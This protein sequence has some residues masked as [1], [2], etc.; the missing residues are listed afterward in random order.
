MFYET[1]RNVERIMV[2]MTKKMAWEVMHEDVI[3]IV[4]NGNERKLN[5]KRSRGFIDW[6]QLKVLIDFQHK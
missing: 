1:F 6:I 2:M 5:E 3:K 4:K